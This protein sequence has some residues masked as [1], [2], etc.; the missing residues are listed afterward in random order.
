MP[1]LLPHPSASSLLV[2]E[3]NTSSWIER[4]IKGQWTAWARRVSIVMSHRRRPDEEL[5]P[6]KLGL[7]VALL[8]RPSRPPPLRQLRL[9]Y[10][11]KLKQLVHHYGKVSDELPSHE[12]SN[13]LIGLGVCGNSDPTR[14]IPSGSKRTKSTGVL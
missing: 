12:K 10:T 9:T 11:K 7:D 6:Q 1:P 5:W 4:R 2:P 13:L 8:L 14:R 3:H